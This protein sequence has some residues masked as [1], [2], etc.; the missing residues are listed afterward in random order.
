MRVLFIGNSFVVANELPALFA[1]LAEDTWGTGEVYTLSVSVNGARLADHLRRA[2]DPGALLHQALMSWPAADRRWDVVVLQ[3]QSQIPGFTR[4]TRETAESFAAARELVERIRPTGATVALLQTWGFW[5]GDAMNRIVYPDFVTMNHRLA[6]GIDA[7]ADALAD[8]LG[9]PRPVVVPIGDA[10]DAVYAATARPLAEGSDFR[11][12]YS[13]ERHPSLEGSYL[14]AAVL[15]RALGDRPV[16]R[17]TW[18]PPG[19][20]PTRAR[21]LREAAEASVNGP[22]SP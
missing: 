16:T 17:A 20:D 10:F 15:V 22:T 1:R 6:E 18:A 13:D 11:R 21:V 5:S 3:E 8:A 14:A 4:D 2:D 7:L 12:L 19:L 9:P